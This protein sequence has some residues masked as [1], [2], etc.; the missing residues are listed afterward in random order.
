MYLGQTH[1][2]CE[3]SQNRLNSLDAMTKKPCIFQGLLQKD[4]K[5]AFYGNVLYA[6]VKK[7][8]KPIFYLNHKQLIEN[9]SNKK[10]IWR[11]S[12]WEF[13][14]KFFKIL[15]SFIYIIQKYIYTVCL[16][17]NRSKPVQGLVR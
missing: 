7:G 8:L 15:L 4:V 10:Y 12:K 16:V 11:F 1:G 3:F 14:L 2:L 5:D 9:F 6:H 17:Q 13:I